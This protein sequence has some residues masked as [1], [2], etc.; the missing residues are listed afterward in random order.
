MV[1]R[2]EGATGGRPL[3][4]GSSASYVWKVKPGRSASLTPGPY[5]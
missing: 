2:H 5:S 1:S 4:L 3:I